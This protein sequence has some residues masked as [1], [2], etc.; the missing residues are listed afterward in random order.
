MHR[1]GFGGG[2]MMIFWFVILVV[3]VVLFVR[4]FNSENRSISQESP[5]EILKKRYAEGSIT[6]KEFEEKK[7][8][9][10]Q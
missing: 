8:D 9:L 4:L 1:M 5:L 6:K 3:G 2:W 7:R 10:L